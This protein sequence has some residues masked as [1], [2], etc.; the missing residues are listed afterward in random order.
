MITRPGYA[1][2][3][4]ERR[5]PLSTVS[6]K[7]T[8]HLTFPNTKPM[9]HRSLVQLVTHCVNGHCEPHRCARI[10]HDCGKCAHCIAV[11]RS[12]HRIAHN[13]WPHDVSKAT[14]L[15]APALCAAHSGETGQSVAKHR[16]HSAKC[17][18]QYFIHTHEAF[19]IQS[20]GLAIVVM[21]VFTA[22]RTLKK[23]THVAYS[24]NAVAASWAANYVVVV[25]VD[26]LFNQQSSSHSVLAEASQPEFCELMTA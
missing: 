17:V 7:L 24:P 22:N 5:N 19:A 14:A 20:N 21:F 2:L 6:Q 8:P 15:V 18:A 4:Q 10:C 9:L 13:L 12:P 1:H 16:V 3:I 11:D 23:Q 25:V 26:R